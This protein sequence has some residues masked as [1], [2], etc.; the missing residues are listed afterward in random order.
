MKGPLPTSLTARRNDKE[1]AGNEPDGSEG[2]VE[3]VFGHDRQESPLLAQR[4]REKWG[5]Q[6]TL[7]VKPFGLLHRLN[8][9]RDI[10]LR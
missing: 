2:P 4:M 10:E 6:L 5:T 9:V 8:R 1:L 7:Q 3:A